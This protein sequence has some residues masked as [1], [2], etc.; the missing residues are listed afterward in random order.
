MSIRFILLCFIPI[1]LI[2]C[3]CVPPSAT[4]DD[5]IRISTDNILQQAVW[6][7]Q[8][9]RETDRL[10]GLFSSADA[11]ERHLAIRAMASVQ[12]SAAI[13]SLIRV[14]NTDPIINNRIWSAFALGQIGSA[15]TLPWLIRSFGQQDTAEYNSPVHAAILEAIGKIGSVNELIQIA[16]VK[17]YEVTD[18]WLLIGQIRAIYRFGLRGIYHIRATESALRY[19]KSAVYP[20]DVRRMAAAYLQRNVSVDLSSEK[21]MLKLVFTGESDVFVRSTLAVLIGRMIDARQ[22]TDFLELLRA[23]TDY[24]VKVNG[25]RALATT[26]KPEMLETILLYLEDTN[27]HVR[28]SAAEALG[29][30]GIPSQA[31]RLLEIGQKVED[32]TVKALVL[33]S[34]LKSTPPGYRN[35]VQAITDEITKALSSTN[36]VY[37]RTRFI[38]AM[39]NSVLNVETLKSLLSADNPP[40]VQTSVISAINQLL[41][42][43]DALSGTRYAVPDN[44]VRKQ[45]VDAMSAILNSKDAGAIA[46]AC[47]VLKNK[48]LGARDY[49][50]LKP[51]IRQALRTLSLP[52]EVE[53]KYELESLLD[54]LNDTI[55]IRQKP[56]H[57]YPIDWLALS[58]ITD[59]TRAVIST[60][61]GQIV[62][63]LYTT[64]APGSVANFVS[65]SNKNFYDGKFIHRVVPNFVIQTGCPRGDGYGGLDYSIRSEFAYCYYDDEGYV[66]M[67]S[68]GKDTEG[69][70]WFIT[71]S[72]TPHLDG[73]YTI[74]GKVVEGMDVVHRIEVG[75]LVQDVRLLRYNKS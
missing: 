75:D 39:G 58:D 41:N 54:Y 2:Y 27:T 21:E 20:S 4:P 62:I 18:D 28:Q 26:E 1:V 36:N 32:P 73:R 22:D 10:L 3:G 33:G 43:Y 34:A 19:V 69:T 6:D 5:E 12:D 31:A 35:T 63:K 45:I 25:L 7:M 23:D 49:I 13:D 16:S 53:T 17:N 44:T 60:T 29:S 9:R 70:Q 8:D 30:V 51:S 38:Q 15:T 59:S 47:T 42:Q 52:K 55:T 37:H 68:A 14:L 40:V 61:K 71:H 57:N 72:P 11:G 50:E 64:E 46:A 66:G 67:A 24:R 65:L 48:N 56:T 74:F